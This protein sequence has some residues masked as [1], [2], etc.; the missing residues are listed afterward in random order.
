MQNVGLLFQHIIPQGMSSNAKQSYV[1]VLL[2]SNQQS[3]FI[4][5]Y[6]PY[7]SRH[8]KMTQLLRLYTKNPQEGHRE[9][10]ETQKIL[11]E[12]RKIIEQNNYSNQILHMMAIQ[13]DSMTTQLGENPSNYSVEL[14]KVKKT[15]K[16]NSL[17]LVNPFSIPIKEIPSILTI[18]LGNND[19]KEIEYSRKLSMLLKKQKKPT[20]PKQTFCF[21][22][23]SVT[24]PPK[25]YDSKS[26]Y[27]DKP[28][29]A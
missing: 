1:T 28:N 6:T 10:Q 26:D 11:D 21:H 17:P 9:N 5:H 2:Q 4:P 7:L 3:L 23:P 22:K 16:N 24:N 29:L 27:Y 14:S 12:T 13:V 25:I 19:L 15:L 20:L 18:K 8:P